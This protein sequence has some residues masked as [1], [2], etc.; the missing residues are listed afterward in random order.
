V[1]GFIL[2]F[3]ILVQILCNSIDIMNHANNLRKAGVK[4]V[5]KLALWYTS[6]NL[7][8]ISA[9]AD[10]RTKLAES[11]MAIMEQL[12]LDGLYLEW[13]WPGC[14]EVHKN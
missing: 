6:S 14:P 2:K 9:T 12:Q 8:R 13:M 11:I 3:T 5:G 1:K 4:V 7:M 10:L